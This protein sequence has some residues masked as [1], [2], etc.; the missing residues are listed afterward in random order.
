MLVTMKEILEKANREGY[1]VAAPNV[2]DD[3]SARAIIAAAERANS[4]VIIDI[5][6]SGF[7]GNE[8]YRMA[9]VCAEYAEVSNVPVAINLDHGKNY[10]QCVAGCASACTSIM[11]DR[12]TLPFEENVSLVSELVKVAHSLGKSVEAEL[13]HVGTNVGAEKE[14]ETSKTM[15]TQDDIRAG[16]T[17]VEEAV[18]YVKQTGID[19]LAVAVGTV[20]G[21][22]PKG[23]VPKIDFDL[24]AELHKAVNVPLVVHGGSGT[25][26]DDM[27]KLGPAG[28][29]KINIMADLVENGIRYTGA[30]VEKHGGYDN[31]Y[32]TSTGEMKKFIEEFYKG[33]EDKLY[34]YLIILGSQ[35]KA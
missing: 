27:A 29:S 23:V 2:I 31:L 11:V 22:Y 21:A 19:A 30:F 20:H 12:S 35:N 25:A 33:Y 32:H 6:P 13:G 3:R 16:F 1:C 8:L 24:I 10:D 34:E 17:R 7:K 15:E 28:I 9:R 4:P 18:E 14:I 26:L 5:A